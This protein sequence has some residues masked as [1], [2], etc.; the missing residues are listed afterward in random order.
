MRKHCYNSI[1]SFYADINNYLNNPIYKETANEDHPKFRGLCLA[2]IQGAK[3]SYPVG[4]EKLSHFKDF[5]VEKDIS[6]KYWNQF[7]G[8][9]IDIDRMMENLDFLLDSHKKRLLPKT[10]DIYINVGEGGDVNYEKLLCKTYA[11]IKI[12]DKLET[13]GVRCS[14]FTCASFETHTRTRTRANRGE[15]GYLEICVKQYADTLNLGALCTAISP[16]MLRYWMFL[17][18]IG[19]Y[20]GV[21]HGIAYARSMPPELKGIIIET[22]SCLDKYA[23]NQ[24]I[25]S[26]K[27]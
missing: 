22:G 19:K 8:W 10:L 2:E 6:I 14:V 21:I 3:Y 12:V 17:F 16:W 20:P 13:L 24:F 11:T 26:I 7:D 27:L 25:E 4:V 5:T 23:A 15:N 1:S 18:I 9:D